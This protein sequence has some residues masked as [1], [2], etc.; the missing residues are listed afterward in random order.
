MGSSSAGPDR[1]AI[2]ALI[3][4]SRIPLAN[5]PRASLLRRFG[6]YPIAPRVALVPLAKRR[7][8]LE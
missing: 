1:P 7:F 8:W 5:D 2:I 6:P 3:I 4:H